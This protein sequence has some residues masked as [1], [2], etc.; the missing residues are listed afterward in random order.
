MYPFKKKKK[1]NPLEFIMHVIGSKSLCMEHI[2]AKRNYFVY[3]KLLYSDKM[4]SIALHLAFL[5]TVYSIVG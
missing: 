2:A 3:C 4:K 5:C 1:K